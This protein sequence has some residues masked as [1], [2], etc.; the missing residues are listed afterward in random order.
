MSGCDRILHV[1]ATERSVLS[2]SGS[3]LSLVGCKGLQEV[4]SQFHNILCG[5]DVVQGYV[6]P[7]CEAIL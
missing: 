7:Y 5:K 2:S 4:M 1:G 6:R 3:N